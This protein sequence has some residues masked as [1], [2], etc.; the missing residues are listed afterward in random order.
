[1]RLNM[2]ALRFWAMSIDN[3]LTVCNLSIELGAKIGMI[4]PDDTAFSY[5]AGRLYAPK[6]EM[7]D[8]ACAYWRTLPSDADARFDIEYVIELRKLRRRLLG[9]RA[10]RM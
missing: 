10:R 6:G 7:F 1:M 3:R 8:R 2:P 4:A 5:L 9:G